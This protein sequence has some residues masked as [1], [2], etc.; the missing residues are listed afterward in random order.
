VHQAGSREFTE[1]RPLFEKSGIEGELVEFI[2][3]MPSAFAG[4]DLIVSR[5]GASTVSEIAA[6]GKPSIL[7][8]FPFAA[9][10]HQL[11]NAEAM[12]RAGAARLVTDSE[13]SG[14]RLFDE[15][16]RLI[17]QPDELAAMGEKARRM[18]HP[19][20]ARRAADVLE[21]LAVR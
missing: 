16:R 20:S 2:T 11:R 4:A 5:S 18:A 1:Y 12:A 19:E 7:V 9:D 10:N 15:V 8:P 13:M 17:D 6:A 3:D 21:S 14:Q